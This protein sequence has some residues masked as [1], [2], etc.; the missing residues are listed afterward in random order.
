M[1]REGGDTPETRLAHAFRSATSRL[2]LPAELEVLVRVFQSH[3]ADFQANP[4]AAKKLLEIG[5][6][7]SPSS[8]DPCELAAY[9]MTAG[10]ILNL[11]ETVTKE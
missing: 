6:T 8:M 1:I 4:D 10:M 5:D 9:T 11:D 7:K 2:P 3:W